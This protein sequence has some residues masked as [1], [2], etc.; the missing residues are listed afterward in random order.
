MNERK[1]T[2]GFFGR[3]W[4]LLWKDNSFKGWIF[5]LIVIFIFIRFIFFPLLSLTTGTT[6]PL[7]I[8]ESCS[9]YHHGDIFSNFNKWWSGHEHYYL[10]RNITKREFDNFKFYNGLDKGDVLFIVGTSPQNIKV[11]DIIV[12]NIP[13]QSVPVIHRVV[14]ITFSNGTYFFSTMGDN[15]AGQQL[16]L[17][18]KINQGQIVGKAVLKAAPFVGW[19]KLIFFQYRLPP[20]ERGFCHAR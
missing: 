16:P 9:M 6:L 4:F 14:N 12:F 2:K 3:F 15:N 13:G 20:Y 17:E 11:G 19:V 7:A 1:D 10:M 5:S 18:K 8:V